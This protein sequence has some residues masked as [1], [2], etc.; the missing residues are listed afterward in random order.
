MATDWTAYVNAYGDLK[1]VWNKIKSGSGEQY[2][3]WNPKG[4]TSISEF[5]RI[6]WADSGESEGRSLT[7]A[8]PPGSP[9]PGSPPPDSPPPPDPTLDWSPPP[10]IPDPELPDAPTYDAPAPAPGE[11][12]EVAAGQT[13]MAGLPTVTAPTI[14]TPAQRTVNPQELVEWR[15]SQ[16]MKTT[17]PYTQQAMTMAKQSAA[18]SGMLNTSIAASAGVDAAIKSMLP[19][20]QQDATT[21]FSQGIE[22]QRAVNEFL[23]QDFLTKAEFRLQDFGAKVSTYNK[24]LQRSHEKNES[25]I[26]RW[27]QKEQNKLDREL[28]VWRDKYDGQLQKWLAEKKISSD[29]VAGIKDC[30]QSALSRWQSSV[31]AVD[32]AYIKGDISVD[33]YNQA[34]K[35][36]AKARDHEVAACRL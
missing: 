9:P 14:N 26:T 22:N 20:A 31:S 29:E 21:L 7:G 28:Q 18:Q 2:N 30:V 15:M 11:I 6:H 27:W 35:N 36:L 4:A 24:A 5:G 25:A 13:A 8:P 19:I 16:M 33:A 17:N 12:D 34:I 3:Y 23:M 10:S 32:A 1:S